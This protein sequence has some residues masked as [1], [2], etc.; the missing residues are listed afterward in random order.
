M[1]FG[2]INIEG[3]GVMSDYNDLLQQLPHKWKLT[4]E[5]AILDSEQ[6]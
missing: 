5:D 6:K 2:E 4:Y 3:Q 1:T